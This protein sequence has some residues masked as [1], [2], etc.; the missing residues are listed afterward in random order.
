MDQKAPENKDLND[1]EITQNMQTNTKNNSSLMLGSIAVFILFCLGT[2]VFLYN[3]N[4]ELKKILAEYQKP[5][6]P[7]ITIVVP[8][9]DPSLEAIVSTPAKNAVVSSPLTVKGTVP[10]GWMFEGVIGVK[11][12]DTTG[13][14]I[15]EAQGKEVNPGSWLSG[16]PV[17]FTSTLTFKTTATSGNILIESDNASGDRQTVKYFN[18]PV[19]FG[20][21]SAS[22]TPSPYA[23]PQSGYVDCMP[24]PNEGVRYECTAEAMNWY[25]ANC[26][27]FKGGAY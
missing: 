8:T 4:K 25:K 27:G 26:P 15:K 5:T 11:L 22:A 2:V 12:V 19:T 23:C 7:P 21:A 3:Q 16:N 17:E 1:S 9:P 13:K 20:T 14:L 24:G 6:S 10:A 18:L